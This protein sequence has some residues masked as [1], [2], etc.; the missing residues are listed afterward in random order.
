MAT[1]F[2]IQLWKVEECPRAP[3]GIHP[4]FTASHPLALSNYNKIIFREIFRP[5]CVSYYVVL[6]VGWCIPPSQ[7]TMTVPQ[8]PPV[9]CLLIDLDDTL[10]QC[11]EISNMVAEKIRQ[12]ML[13]KLGTPVDEV[14][15]KCRELYLNYGTTLAGLVV[16]RCYFKYRDSALSLFHRIADQLHL[17]I[18]SCRL[19][20][21]Q[22]TLRTGMLKFT[23]HFLTKNTLSLILNSRLF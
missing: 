12:Y 9:Q 13:T 10:Y 6:V 22:S 23:A 21:T 20:A 3:Q 2:V 15:E 8:R 17:P 19:L 18:R 1:P 16:R 11:P 5:A 14:E 4:N 7:P